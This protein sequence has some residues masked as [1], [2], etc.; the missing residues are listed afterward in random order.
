MVMA[1]LHRPVM[2]EEVLFHLVGRS[3][4]IY[5]DATLGDGGHA[6]AICRKLGPRGHLVGLDWDR[7][8]LERAAARLSGHAGQVTLLHADYTSLAAILEERGHLPVDGI[9]VD[10]GASTLQLTD[11][12]RGFSFHLEGGLDMRMDR[13]RSLTAGE[14]VNSYGAAELA[15]LF[16]RLGEE[17]WSRRIAAAIVRRREREGP[18]AGSLELAT[19]VREAIPARYRRRGGHPARRVFQAL[20]LA[21]NKELENISAV[22]PQAVGSLAPGGRLCVIA[23]HSLEDRLVKHFIRSRSG[24]CSCPPGHPCL[25]AGQAE[26]KPLTRGALRPAQQEIEN[27]PRAR[28]ARL[29]AAVKL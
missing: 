22:L 13:S 12:D 19:I 8:A 14:I 17:R 26:L 11:A 27:N 20:R 29:R 21:V 2:E 4:G 5:V 3:E 28:S 15:E 7:A 25:C 6:L 18:I 16:F 23:Y 24:R 1:E 9:L 10:L